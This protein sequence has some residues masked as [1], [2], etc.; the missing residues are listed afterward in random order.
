MIPFEHLRD[1]SISMIWPRHYEDAEDFYRHVRQLSN[2][3]VRDKLARQDVD[4]R[5]HCEAAGMLPQLARVC[6][7]YSVP[8]YSCSGF[9][10]LTLKH[11]LRGDCVDSFTYEGKPTVVLHL[12][13]YDPSGESIYDSMREDVLA[14]L[15]EDVPHKLPEEVALF[16]RVALTPEQVFLYRLPTAP[17]KK[18]D[19][20]TKS[21]KGEGTCQLEALPPDAVAV[22]LREAIERHLD[23]GVLRQD[24]EI[25]AQE[26]RQIART[27]PGGAA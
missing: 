20:R 14:F 27:L 15:E 17:P 3:Y 18:S 10:S 13:D 7:G 22:L 6:E 1:D 2:L 23:L 19:K 16:E 11:D 24:C 12:G 25:E 26:R 5:V 8:V 4:M 21:W 9:D